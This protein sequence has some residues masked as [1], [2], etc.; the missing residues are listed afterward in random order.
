MKFLK[1][2]LCSVKARLTANKTWEHR[3]AVSPLL[4]MIRLIYPRIL[5]WNAETKQMTIN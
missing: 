1:D 4:G 3:T 2:L 5:D